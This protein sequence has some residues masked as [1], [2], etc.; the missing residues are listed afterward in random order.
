MIWTSEKPTKAGWWW[1]EGAG[2]RTVVEVYERSGRL[3]ASFP[4]SEYEPLVAGIGLRWS[5]EPIPLPED[6][7]TT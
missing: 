6:G 7:E 5:S 1:Y 4:G 3:I 2:R